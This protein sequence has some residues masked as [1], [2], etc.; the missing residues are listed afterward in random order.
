MGDKRSCKN[1]D[2]LQDCQKM[3]NY[4]AEPCTLYREKQPAEGK[5]VVK[6]LR[7]E[8]R[9]LKDNLGRDAWEYFQEGLV[10][11]TLM[12]QLIVDKIETMKEGK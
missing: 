1:C 12:I 10:S 8:L 6:D 4:K 3:I 9:L 7:T 11:K 2:M 5:P